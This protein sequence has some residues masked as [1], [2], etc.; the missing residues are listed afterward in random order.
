MSFNLL[1]A[2]KGHFSGDLISKAASFLG[3]S[4]GGINKALGGLIPTVLSGITSKA[5]TSSGAEEVFSMAKEQHGSGLLGNLGGVFSGGSLLSKGA[6]LIKGLFGGKLGG[7]VDAIAGFAGIKSSSASSLMSL[8]APVALGT[9]G[10]HAADN[11]LGASGISSLLASGKSALAGLLPAGIGSLLGGIGG[12]ASA[13]A[14][15][16]S[17]YA[18]DAA[19]RAGGGIKWLLPLLLLAALGFLGWWLLKSKSCGKSDGGDH[20]TGTPVAGDTSKHGHGGDTSTAHMSTGT[21]EMTKVTLPG[22]VTLDAAK[23]SIEDML[24]TFLATG[25]YKKT[26]DSL[27]KDKWFDFSSVNFK[28][29]TAEL[30]DSSKIQLGNVAKIIDAYGDAKVKIGAYTDKKGDDAGNM[31]LSQRRADAV[32]ASLKSM[33]KSKVQIDGAEGYG[34]KFAKAD[35]NAPD[36]ERVKDRHISLRVKGQ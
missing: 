22:G 29:G 5:S 10:K 13:A 14:S 18:D 21:V 1:D 20:T 30:T 26:A 8:A 2:V 36:E 11:N 31:K 12:S 6:D 24:S 27:M 25:D 28:F 16:V 34:E 4:D 35:E 7:I 33:V 9:L 32:A 3:E 23:G 19:G 15:T 17:N